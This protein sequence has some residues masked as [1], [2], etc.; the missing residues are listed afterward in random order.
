MKTP[1]DPA[2]GSPFSANTLPPDDLYPLVEARHA[3]P[4][5]ILGVRPHGAGEKILRAFAPTASSVTFLF[6]D[7]S[8]RPLVKVH[9]QGLFEAVVPA[10]PSSG[11]GGYRLELVHAN[12]SV[13][14]TEDPYAFAP[15]LGNLD[16]HLLGEGRHME[17]YRVLGA[18]PGIREGVAGTSFAVWAPNAQRVSVVGDF[19]GWDGR[20]HMM[21]RLGGSGVW[22]IFLPGVG[23]GAHYKFEIRGLHGD[24]FLKTDPFGFFAQHDLRT[25]CIVE[26]LG[27]HAWNDSAW[28]EERSRRDPY[29]SPMSVY[30]VHLGSWRRPEDEP[31]RPLS[32]RELAR[33]LVDYVKATGFTHVEFL[34]VME[35][36]FD[37]S[38]GY[39]VVNF[40]APSSRF[41]SPDE[42]R[43]LID[44]L[45]GAGIGVLL[46]WVPGHFPKDAHGLARFDGTALYEHEDPR[47]GEHRDWGT[48]I[49]NYGRNEV[50][51]FLVANA[52]FW[53]DEFHIDGLRVDAVASMLYLDY[54]RR[55]GEWIPNRY[56]GRENLEAIGFLKG[57][58][59]ACHARHP[60]V[61][62][63]AEESTAW[64]GVSKPVHE[65]GLGF[66]FKWNMGWMND[67]LRYIAREPVHRQFHQGE[68]TFSMLYNYHEHFLLVLS[69]DEVVHGKGSLLGKMPGDDWQKAANLRLFLSWMWAHPGK[70][71]LFQGGEIGQWGE[72][73]H[74][75]GIDWSLT[76]HWPHGGIQALVSRLNALYREESALTLLD[77]RPEGFEWVDFRDTGNTVWSFLRKAPAGEGR[78]ILVVVNATP[79]LRS[80]YR[81]GV[82]RAGKCTVLLDS[83]AGDFGGSGCAG[84]AEVIHSMDQ[85]SHGRPA[86][87][88]LDLPPLGVLYLALPV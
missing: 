32:Y 27:T 6:A 34:P 46:D 22:E 40:F 29:S 60:G 9:A 5:R 63:I 21:R 48:L 28:M 86:S 13:S 71:L 76:E 55:E 8:R 52:L 14:L 49:F 41:G 35:H 80:G 59:T 56:G 12:G 31:D 1:L 84:N 77:D 30:E 11:P 15:T 26:G 54:S 67:S 36:P 65:G 70:K 43:H 78:D 44:V 58:N 45:H 72:W 25:A 87:L 10:V 42:F 17:A 88:L 57:F 66:S 69:H 33:D 51:N 62:T 73:D 68:I 61:M 20:V 23:K 74:S 85:P 47:L 64:P 79:V 81:L 19:N 3:D 4:H 18:H 83:D 82:P 16:L 24:V 75:R 39:Q 7:G 38:W 2:H 50:R 53:L 37:G